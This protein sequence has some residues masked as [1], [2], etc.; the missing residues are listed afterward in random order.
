M[1]LPTTN[2]API[3]GIK[4]AFVRKENPVAKRD[5]PTFRKGEGGMVV[6]MVV[7]MVASD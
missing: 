5:G 3:G 6:G 2:H 1:L 7:G 4:T